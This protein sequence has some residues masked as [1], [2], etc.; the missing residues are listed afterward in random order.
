MTGILA[1]N[2]FLHSEKYTQQDKLLLAGA[3]A[4]GI[5]LKIYSN[6]GLRLG[7]AESRFCTVL[8]QGCVV[9]LRLGTAGAAGV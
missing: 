3:K 7:C 6:L 4:C 8:G 5:N 9:G 2:A 1:I